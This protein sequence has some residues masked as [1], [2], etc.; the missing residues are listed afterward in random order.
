M[1]H[2]T[3]C[4]PA[5]MLPLHAWVHFLAKVPWTEPPLPQYWRCL[6]SWGSAWGI[7]PDG[8][9]GGEGNKGEF[10]ILRTVGSEHYSGLIRSCVA[11]PID[12]DDVRHRVF[13][14]T[15]SG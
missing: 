12:F 10:R 14:R 6:N 13:D 7:A 15:T 3:E 2:S 4:W 9:W 8:E 1:L 11:A 5:S